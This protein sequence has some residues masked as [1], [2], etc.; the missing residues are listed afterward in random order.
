MRLAG[1]V[2]RHLGYSSCSAICPLEREKRKGNWRRRESHLAVPSLP[3]LPATAL[4][5]AAAAGRVPTSL[6]ESLQRARALRIAGARL[7]ESGSRE[8][9]RRW[10]HVCGPSSRHATALVWHGRLAIDRATKKKQTIAG[11]DRSLARSLWLSPAR[12]PRSLAR[13]YSLLS[14]DRRAHL[15]TPWKIDSCNV[16]ASQLTPATDRR[17]SSSVHHVNT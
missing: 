16:E 9:R 4:R 3:F 15:L 10:L 14:V 2:L 8:L 12:W 11:N 5:A 17:Q 7:R 13:L 6:E 1:R